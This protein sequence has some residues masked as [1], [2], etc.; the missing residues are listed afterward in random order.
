[1]YSSESCSAVMECSDSFCFPSVGWGTPKLN[2]LRK[3][4][5]LG[6]THHPGN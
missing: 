2:R 4:E 5:P 1:M 6:E 3:L